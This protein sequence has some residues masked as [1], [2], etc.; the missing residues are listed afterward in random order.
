MKKKNYCLEGN[1]HKTISGHL[2]KI[3]VKKDLCLVMSAET[4]LT[5]FDF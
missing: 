4:K 1:N 2:F 3:N 5:Y